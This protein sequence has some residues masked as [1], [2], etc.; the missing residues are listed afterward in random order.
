MLLF[1]LERESGLCRWRPSAR[2]LLEF[3]G[4]RSHRHPIPLA[5]TSAYRCRK[6][7]IIPIVKVKPA[8]APSKAGGSG[9]GDT[10]APAAKKQRTASGGAEQQ[11]QKSGG[12]GGSSSSGGSGGGLGGLLGA[13]GSDSDSD[14]EAASGG[15][16]QSPA[17][18]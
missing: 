4:F 10:D 12:G 1:W 9:G 11:Q 17:Q 13:Y 5:L 18:E 2:R 16:Q 15:K 6:K 8:A 3:T 7:K 14:G